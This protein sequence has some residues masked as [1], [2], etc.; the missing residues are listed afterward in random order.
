MAR[1]RNDLTGRGLDAGTSSSAVRNVAFLKI[2]IAN[3]HTESMRERINTPEG[4]TRCGRACADHQ[5]E[6]TLAA[7]SA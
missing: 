2:K 7:R 3:P 4:R 5:I 6:G 1:Y